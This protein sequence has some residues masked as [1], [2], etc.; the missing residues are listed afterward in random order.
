MKNS[1]TILLLLGI[2]LVLVEFNACRK[3]DG[4]PRETESF[5]SGWRFFLGDTPE[6]SNRFFDDS[7][8]RELEL[9]HDWAIEGDFSKDHPSGSGGGAPP[10][11]GPK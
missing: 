10:P 7:G 9:P 2:L 8:W 11:E 4:S 3:N 5:N 1:V 6:A